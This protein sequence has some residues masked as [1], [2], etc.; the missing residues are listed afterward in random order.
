MGILNKFKTAFGASKQNDTKETSVDLDA[1]IEDIEHDPFAISDQN[2]LYAGLNELGGYY[3]FQTVIVGAFKVKTKKGGQLSI[4]G[5]DLEL[6][7]DSDS[8]EFESDPTDVKGRWITKID[9]QIDEEDAAKIV[10]P[11][12][13]KLELTSKNQNITFSIYKNEN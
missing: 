5:K 9:F 7:L 12:L 8:F 13:H 11:N 3:F 6:L 4:T 1:I 2:V 10:K